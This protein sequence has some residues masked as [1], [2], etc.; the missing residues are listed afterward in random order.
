MVV[1]LEREQLELMRRFI[2]ENARAPHTHAHTPETGPLILALPKT[3]VINTIEEINFRALQLS[4][5][6]KTIY[7]F[8]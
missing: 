5:R 6:D 1:S 2:S 3:T 7:F 4:N 8:S